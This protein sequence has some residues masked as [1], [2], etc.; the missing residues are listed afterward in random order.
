MFYKEI[1]KKQEKIVEMLEKD[2]DSFQ[3]NIIKFNRF[4]K[5][6]MNVWFVIDP[7]TGIAGK[8]LELFLKL[9]DDLSS[10]LEGE[11]QENINKIF[12]EILDKYQDELDSLNEKINELTPKASIVYKQDKFE[13]LKSHGISSLTN[14][15]DNEFEAN[16]LTN[17]NNPEDYIA[18][19]NI[20]GIQTDITNYKI[21]I[22]LPKNF[23]SDSSTKIQVGLIKIYF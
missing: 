18:V 2:K 19:T 22:K 12:G 4:M 6:Y 10:K 1:I 7:V 14:I 20:C 23:N 15:S 11:K 17:L 9:F 3:D 5:P 13:I 21:N 8:G 16:L